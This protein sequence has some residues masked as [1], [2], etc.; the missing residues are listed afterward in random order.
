MG[1]H[2]VSDDSMDQG[3]PH[4]LHPQHVSQPSTWSPLAV[5]TPEINT[6]LCCSRGHGQHHSLKWQHRPGTSM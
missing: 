1:F 6:V 2:E 4:A 5:Q 3:H